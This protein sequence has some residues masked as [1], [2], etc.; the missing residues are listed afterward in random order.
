M[1]DDMMT[2]PVLVE[3]NPDADLLREMIGFACQRLMEPQI[4][5]KTGAASCGAASARRVECRW[6][7]S[8]VQDRPE[9]SPSALTLTP[10]AEGTRGG[11]GSASIR[12]GASHSG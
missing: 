11:S 2:L 5:S 8:S 6:S 1:T 4:K 9:M 3:K 12:C 7:R 10:S